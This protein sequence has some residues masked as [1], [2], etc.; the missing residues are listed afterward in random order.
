MVDVKHL[1]VIRGRQ[2]VGHVWAGVSTAQVA[3]AVAL[4]RR[5]HTS[6]KRCLIA[7]AASMAGQ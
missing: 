1:A 5:S 2:A 6:H 3:T 7:I 4:W